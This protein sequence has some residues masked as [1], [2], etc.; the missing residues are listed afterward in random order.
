MFEH[1][2]FR[3]R[4]S[5]S[6]GFPAR[7]VT[8]YTIHHFNVDLFKVATVPQSQKLCGNFPHNTSQSGGCPKD[9]N[10]GH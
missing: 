4:Y 9:V 3:R 7:D 5:M 1:V 2:S 6:H 8:T 10:F